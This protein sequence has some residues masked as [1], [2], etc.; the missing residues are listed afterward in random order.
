MS[1]RYAAVIRLLLPLSRAF[2]RFFGSALEKFFAALAAV[3]RDI[4][5]EAERVYLDLFPDTTRE[6]ARWQNQFGITVL[7]SFSSIAARSLKSAWMS[8]SGSQALS[9]LQ[10]VLRGLDPNIYI[11]G[12]IPVRNPRDSNVVRYA[13]CGYKKTVCGNRLAAC[14]YREGDG[15]FQPTVIINGE[16]ESLM[17]LP[18]IPAYWGLCF[19][20]GGTV[21]RDE[22]GRITYIDK[23]AVSRQFK[24][25]IEYFV[26]KSKPA[27]TKAIIYIEYVDEPAAVSAA[28]TQEAE[29]ETEEEADD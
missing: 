19:F 18:N 10:D 20:V 25:F 7:D 1:Q 11:N 26:L 21:H 15:S 2:R 28:L 3:P 4:R 27:H 24:S 16:D 9:R 8:K 5:E 12:N 22:Q 17:S 29:E 14:D 23:L 6:T 13:L